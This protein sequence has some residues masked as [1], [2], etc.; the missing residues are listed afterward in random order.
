MRQT[1][2]RE[3]G[4]SQMATGASNDMPRDRLLEGLPVAERRIDV[5]GI[6]TSVLEGGQGPPMVLLHGG[7]PA[8]GI[9]WTL[10][11]IR[12][13]ARSYRLVVP[14]LPG[15][16]ESAPL[17]HLDAETFNGWFAGLLGLTCPEKP[18]IVAHSLPASLAARFA[19]R[20]DGLLRRLVLMGPP[21][22]GRLRP[23]VGFML[24]SLRAGLRPSEGTLERFNRWAFHDLDRT[25]KQL[26]E[27]YEALTDYVL[28]RARVPSVKRTMRQLVKAGLQQIPDP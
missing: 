1:A 26:G 16:G 24:A 13:L 4:R 23:P 12:Q 8:G 18:T 28:S 19:T 15:V 2:T 27:R 21:A 17:D 11:P 6:V 9:V 3:K 5:D 10:G 22:L 14:D 20:H 25:R 7:S